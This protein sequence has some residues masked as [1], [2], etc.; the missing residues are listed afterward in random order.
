MFNTLRSVYTPKY[1]VFNIVAAITYYFLYVYLIMAQQNGAFV[2]AISSYFIYA[3]VI[4]SSI[5]LT[6]AIYAARNTKNNE[7]KE[8]ASLLGTGTAVFSAVVGGC[9]CEA[10]LIY[11]LTA[12]GLST[13]TTFG[14]DNFVAANQSAIFSLMIAINFF[15][16][17]YYLDK[18]SKPSCRL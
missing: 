13:A 1:I 3:V 5:M 18:L 11:G 15:V 4:T 14:I 17:L 6:I 16:V 2:V 12:F 8:V 7:A 9:A 10:P